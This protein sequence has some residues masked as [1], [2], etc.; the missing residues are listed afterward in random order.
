MA[1]KKNNLELGQVYQPNSRENKRKSNE[2]VKEDG[3][4]YQ[5]GRH[6]EVDVVSWVVWLG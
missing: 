6:P 1:R 4:L 2:S 3:H 5:L